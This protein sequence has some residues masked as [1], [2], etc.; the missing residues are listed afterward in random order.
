MPSTRD[1]PTF[2]CLSLLRVPYLFHRNLDWTMENLT[3]LLYRR[4][5]FFFFTLALWV[6]AA[7]SLWWMCDSFRRTAV[8]WPPKKGRKHQL[9]FLKCAKTNKKDGGN[10]GKL[11]YNRQSLYREIWTCLPSCLEFL[12]P[13]WISHAENQVWGKGNLCRTALASHMAKPDNSHRPGPRPALVLGAG[14]VR[15]WDMGHWLYVS[16]RREWRQLQA[17]ERTDE[18]N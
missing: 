12:L 4:Q 1:L 6:L 8:L 15:T 3:V 13:M 2:V 17:T 5:L 11:L 7:V 16:A 10:T 9:E 14:L 18:L